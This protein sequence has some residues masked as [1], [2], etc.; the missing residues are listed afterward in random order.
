MSIKATHFGECQL[1]GRQQ[2][3]PGGLM[4]KHG[5]TVEWSMFQ[6]VCP[7][8]HFQPYEKSKD[9]IEI[10][11]PAVAELVA[12][13][14][15][16]IAGL[17]ANPLPENKMMANLYFPWGTKLGG[18]KGGYRWVETEVRGAGYTAEVLHPESRGGDAPKWERAC[19]VDYNET[20]RIAYNNMWIKNLK[21]G[22]GHSERYLKWLQ[23]RVASWKLKKCKLVGA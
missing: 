3:L 23:E 18:K 13:Q 21:E 8:S 5:Y 17:V 1:C 19:G 10:R 22:F 16:R 6:G 12:Q 2:K 11:I 9:Q 15:K 7:G 14:H 20:A 4:A